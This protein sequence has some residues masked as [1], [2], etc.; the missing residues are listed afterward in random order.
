MQLG[1]HVNNFTWPGGP[2]AIAPTLAGIAQR[3]EAAGI[4]T[5]S[6]MD[7]FF[8]IQGQGPP[9]LEM[10]EAYTTLGFIA[11][12]TQKLRLGTIVTGVSYRHPGLLMKQV[13]TLDVL[14]GGRAY[15]GI[16]AAWYEEEHVG[17]GVPFPPLKERFERL[18][19]T[20]KIARQ[21]LAGDETPINGKYYQLTR[22]MC[23]PLPIQKPRPMIVVGGSGER[24]TLKLVAKY[25]DACN[26]FDRLGLD[27]LRH[28]LEVLRE[29]CET[30]GRPY[31][32]IV[33]G[34]NGRLRL[35]RD[36]RNGSQTPA[37][38]LEHIAQLHELGMSWVNVSIPNAHEPDAFDL[39]GSEIIPAMQKLS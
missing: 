26:I 27:E 19:E 14:S 24:K 36:G 31:A 28:K 11:A 5:L 38:A 6:V 7:H 15:L 12:K 25:A 37:A 29:H 35:T 21:M 3:A 22:P 10:L 20:L 4:A 32:E 17:L 2:T 16:G 39:I 18:E 13:A 1:I 9:E 8:Q 30:V 33:K 34:V 23:H